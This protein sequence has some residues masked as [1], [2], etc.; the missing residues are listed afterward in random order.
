MYILQINT[1]REWKNQM[2]YYLNIDKNM[3]TDTN[4]ITQSE[5]MLGF[6]SIGNNQWMKPMA[7]DYEN[8]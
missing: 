2:F 6:T 8:K 5:V 4:T 3:A 1:L 7:I